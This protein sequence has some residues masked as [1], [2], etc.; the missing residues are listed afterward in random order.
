MRVAICLSG[1]SR[2]YNQISLPILHA[3]YF[4]STYNQDGYKPKEFSENPIAYHFFDHIETNL[5]NTNELINYF[6]PKQILLSDDVCIEKIKNKFNNIKT[7]SGV[8]LRNVALMFYKIKQSNDLKKQYEIDNNFKYDF[9]F[10]YRF[11][12]KLEHINFN[13]LENS[14]YIKRK[15]ENCFYDMMYGGNSDIMNIASNCF[16]W[17]MLEPIENLIKIKDAEHILFQYLNCS[18][19]NININEQFNYTFYSLRDGIY[20]V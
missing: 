2:I 5:I 20:T 10:R 17:L 4:I 8:I 19:P 16:E 18:L 3:D 12:T 7:H 6:K 15:N 11:D 14:L 1:H 9:V 13:N